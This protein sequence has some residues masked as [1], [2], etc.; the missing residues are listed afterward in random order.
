LWA[1]AR[2]F[3]GPP[4]GLGLRASFPSGPMRPTK[5]VDRKRGSKPSAIRNQSLSL[6]A[7]SARGANRPMPSWRHPR[8]AVM[9]ARPFIALPRGQRD[10][11][12]K[13]KKWGNITQDRQAGELNQ[14]PQ[15]YAP[16]GREQ[17]EQKLDDH[18]ISR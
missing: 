1:T 8:M 12:F 3:T 4:A 14:P 18:R 13:A 10:W 16:A 9:S 2:P 7:F 11:L 6:R 15:A 5:A 17:D